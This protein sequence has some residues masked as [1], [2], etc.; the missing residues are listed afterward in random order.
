MLVRTPCPRSLQLSRSCGAPRS[1]GSPT[2]TGRRPRP[3]GWATPRRTDLHRRPGVGLRGTLPTSVAREAA[4]AAHALARLSPDPTG[5]PGWREYHARFLDR[6]GSGPPRP[7]HP[8][9]SSPGAVP[10]ARRCR[11]RPAPTSSPRC[12]SFSTCSP[13]TGVLEIGAATGINAALLAELTG[14]T[15]RVA[16]VEIDDDLADGARA[17]LTAAGY[18]EIDVVCGDGAL[19]HPDGAPYDRIVVPNGRLVVPVRLHGSGLTRVLPL[20]L[21]EPDR[22]IS[23]SAVVCGFVPIRGADEHSDNFVRLAEDVVLAVDESD[24]PDHDALAHALGHRALRHWTGIPVDHDVP[25][26]HLDLWLANHPGGCGFGRL[27]VGATAR[28]NGVDP[29]LRW[30]GAAL[31][32]GATVAHLVVRPFGPVADE[33]GIVAHGPRSDE[34]RDRLD[35]ILSTWAALRP[36]QPTIIASPASAARPGEPAVTEFVRRHTRLAIT[37]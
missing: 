19:G 24:D 32:C 13:D 36:D 31:Y 35:V 20:D 8:G 15:G 34:L 22:M 30:A 6:Y 33:L 1:A 3:H 12:S 26:E 28:A 29:A 10:T 27:S 4:A 7:T 14:P 2:A 21:V 16:T 25:A 37:W 5:H 11:P 17:S 18:D 23:T 9:R